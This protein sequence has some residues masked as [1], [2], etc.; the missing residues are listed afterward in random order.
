MQQKDIPSGVVNPFSEKFLDTWS[1]WKLWRVEHD[2]FKYKGVI[3]EQMALKLLV[4]LSGGEEEKAVKI[5]E[6]S[7]SRAWTGFYP[8][9]S[10]NGKSK[11]QSASGNPGS[12]ETGTLRERVAKAA[13]QRYGGGEQTP[14]GTHLKAV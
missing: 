5:I 14:D 6:Q 8:L 4:E 13:N 10:G 11:K 12:T 3:S 9:K 1:L 2:N 7:I